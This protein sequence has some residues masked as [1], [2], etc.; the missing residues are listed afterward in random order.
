MY[1]IITC[2]YE[3]DLIKK[4]REKVETSFSHYKPMGIFSDAQGQLSPGGPIRPKFEL[5]QALMHVIIACKYEKDR[6]KNSR[7]KVETPF[8]PL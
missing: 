3:K 7:E 8:S 6:M 2:K 4:S 1:V 5:V